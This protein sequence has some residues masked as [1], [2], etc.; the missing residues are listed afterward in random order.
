MFDP[1]QMHLATGAIHV[2]HSI[3]PATGA[4]VQP[5]ITST[6]FAR[7]SEGHLVPGRDIY[8]R[9]SNPNRRSLE[10][11][12]AWLEGGSEALAF[13]SGQAAA[14]AVFQSL[15]TGSHVLLPSDLYYNTK[16]LVEQVFSSWGLTYTSVDMTDLEATQAAILPNSRLIWIETPSNPQL[17]ITSIPE[18][19]Q[20]AHEK[21]LY[22]V[23]DN[24]WA[25]PY[26]CQP[27]SLGADLSMHS[28]TKYLGG[29]SDI[30]GGVLIAN[31]KTDVSWWQQLKQIQTLGGGVPSPFD[32][33]L[34]QRSLCTFPIR[35][36]AHCE[37]AQLLAHFLEEHPAIEAVYYPGLV[38]H[39]SHSV[40]QKQMTRGFGGM[41][42]VLVH[43]SE[44][45]ALAV[46]Q[47]LQ[48]FTHATSLGGVE[49]LVEH[50]KSVEGIHSV[51]PD[52]L[53]RVS[54]GIEC[55]DDLIFD[56]AQALNTTKPII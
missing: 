6:T 38:S 44:K 35:M 30:L 42:S 56:W 3:D 16:L 21:G 12:L 27:L 1:S 14:Y 32:C 10:E 51:S 13:S 46:A 23:C 29:H 43:G 19:V 47:R 26:C 36:Q 33:W 20:M 48:L 31:D 15:G 34:L 41:L 22:V 52:N 54:V 8:T 24:T 9:A 49:S 5:L 18:I 39:S 2:G 45:E 7:D 53:L 37:N 55:I 40:A 17:R 50:R 28:T 25:T 11:K 4:V